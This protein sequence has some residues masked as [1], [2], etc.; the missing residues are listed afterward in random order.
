M[1]M[2]MD[3][4]QHHSRI[5]FEAWK[6]LWKK[7]CLANKDKICTSHKDFLGIYKDKKAVLF[8]YGPSFEKNIEE[9]KALNWKRED[10]VIGCVD[11]AFRPLIERG[12]IPD[13]CLIADGSIDAKLWLDGAPK[14]VFK[15]TILIANVY[16]NP[17]WPSAWARNDSKERILWYLNKDN[18]ACTP[19]NK[20]G[21]AEYFA[22]IANYYEVI[23]AGSNVGNSLV[24][25][26]RK[27][28]GCRTSYLFAYD[29]CWGH[30]EYYGV[31]TPAKRYL[32]PSYNVVDNNNDL[33]FT[34]TNME[35]SA[36]WLDQYIVH[37]KQSY[38][39]DI[40]NLTGRGILKQGKVLA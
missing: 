19:N 11:K 18:I 12:I 37:A 17:G 8:S 10:Y 33:V 40:F 14:E 38:G 29:Y 36:G 25:F 2:S 32:V 28:F 13:F 30:G 15:K 22:P 4:V 24:I 31:E 20:W 16:C 1:K 9:F 3:V 23:E 34:T 21:T 35:F 5:A 7:N 26:S 6:E 39:V 27:I